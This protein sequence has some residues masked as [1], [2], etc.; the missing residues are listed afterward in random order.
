M[1]T[2]WRDPEQFLESRRCWHQR[3]QQNAKKRAFHIRRFFTRKGA[4]LHSGA[5]ERDGRGMNPFRRITA[6]SFQ[7]MRS[8]VISHRVPR[9]DSTEECTGWPIS[10]RT[11]FSR[12]R[13][14]MFHHH[15]WAVGSYSSGPPAGGTPQIKVNPTQVRQEMGY[16]ALTSLWEFRENSGCPCLLCPIFNCTSIIL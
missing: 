11:G 9:S 7:C 13:F 2:D 12:L 16:P 5:G 15:A 4:H 10:W 8:A 3:R 6:Y 1:N 14:G